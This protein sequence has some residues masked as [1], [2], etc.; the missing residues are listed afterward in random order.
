MNMRSFFQ[1]VKQD[2][3]LI[4][5]RALSHMKMPYMKT[6]TRM[7]VCLGHMLL[8]LMHRKIIDQRHY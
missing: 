5:D 2:L 4:M 8:L 3:G 6:S 7:P 1:R